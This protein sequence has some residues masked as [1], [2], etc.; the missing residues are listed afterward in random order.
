MPVPLAGSLLWLNPLN[1]VTPLGNLP[2]SVAGAAQWTN[3]ESGQIHGFGEYVWQG[4][5]EL[6]APSFASIQV[7][8]LNF[9]T[10]TLS[11]DNVQ[12][13]FF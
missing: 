4:V 3:W 7:Y 13:E 12:S 2:A 10:L 8:Y 1:I 9:G 6:F 11:M 5:F